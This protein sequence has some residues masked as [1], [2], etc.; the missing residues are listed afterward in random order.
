MNPI[1]F[2]DLSRQ[3]N[4]DLI[5]AAQR[6]RLVRSYRRRHNFA[7]SAFRSIFP[8]GVSGMLSIR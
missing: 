1:L 7:R 3:R 2:E 8:T 5:R 4:R 6:E